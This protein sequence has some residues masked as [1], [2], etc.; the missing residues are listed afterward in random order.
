[1]KRSILISLLVIGAAATLLGAGTF[2]TWNTSGSDSGTITAGALAIQVEG[3][4]ASL[5]FSGSSG[6]C[7]NAVMPGDSCS[8]TDVTVT[9]NGSSAF[10]KFL[11]KRDGVNPD[12]YATARAEFYIV[13]DG[14][15]YT[16]M[17]TPKKI[18]AQTIWL[19]P[20]AIV[21]QGMEVTACVHD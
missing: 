18:G 16:L 1:M 20:G 9:N 8:D 6:R 3:S 4:G 15:V 2:A 14:A 19:A 17:A 13:C 11:I 10:V 7:P 12:I 5:G 21:P